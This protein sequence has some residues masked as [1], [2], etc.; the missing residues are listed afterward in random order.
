[1]HLKYPLC[2]ATIILIPILAGIVY[3]YRKRQKQTVF[4]PNISIFKKA[5]PSFLRNT[6]NKVFTVFNTLS[7]FGLIFILL[8]LT[9]RPQERREF[10]E[11]KSGIDIM[12]VLDGSGSM[13]YTLQGGKSQLTRAREV[14]VDFTKRLENDRIGLITFSGTAMTL[15]PLTFDYSIIDYYMEQMTDENAIWFIEG[16]GTAIG[17]A[18]VLAA[19]K[20]PEE[21]SEDRTQ[22]IIL[23]TD[24][25]ATQGIDPVKAAQH[26]EKKGIKIYG[27]FASDSS[28][29]FGFD[30]LEEISQTA[31]GKAYRA[32]NKQELDAAFSDIEDLERTELEYSTNVVWRDIPTGFIV[33]SGI[34]FVLYV[35]SRFFVAEK[36]L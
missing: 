13:T 25:E 24:G 14:I 18:V 6:V 11:T 31:G 12:L 15:S 8:I 16:G 2:L 22:I 23:I 28:F 9:A 21:E 17:D 1:M 7:L 5:S 33:A 36:Q 30:A 19:E 10:R 20:F 4:V 32:T 29:Q 3:L 26:A 34:I 27:I 35:L